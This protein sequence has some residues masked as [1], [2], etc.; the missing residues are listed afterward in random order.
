MT[1]STT[2]ARRVLSLPEERDCVIFA[3]KQEYVLRI[4]GIKKVRRGSVP[5][6]RNAS[7]PPDRPNAASYAQQPALA[8]PSRTC[9]AAS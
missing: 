9:T 8:L 4:T 7:S 6:H 5:P 2:L 3:Q 1:R